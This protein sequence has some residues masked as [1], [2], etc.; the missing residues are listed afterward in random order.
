MLNLAMIYCNSCRGQKI[1]VMQAIGNDIERRIRCTSCNSYSKEQY[2]QDNQQ[3]ICIETDELG[4][5]IP[6]FTIPD[7]LT[8]CQLQREF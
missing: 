3:P 4:N 8:N 2:L 5:G 1:L 6:Q 7:V